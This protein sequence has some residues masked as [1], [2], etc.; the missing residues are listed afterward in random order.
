[1]PEE[2]ETFDKVRSTLVTDHLTEK[3]GRVA[4]WLTY[5]SEESP[6]MPQRRLMALKKED[7]QKWIGTTN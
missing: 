6:K 3:R 5:V 2:Q 1:M 7:S 4:F